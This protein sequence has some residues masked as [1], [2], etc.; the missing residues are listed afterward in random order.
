MI[1][2]ILKHQSLS[3]ICNNFVRHIGKKYNN[4]ITVGE[5]IIERFIDKQINIGFGYKQDNYTPFFSI[6]NNFSNFDVVFNHHQESTGYCALSYAKYTNNIGLIVSTSTCGFT[7]ICKALRDAYYNNNPLLFMSFYDK[8]SKS[9]LTESIKLERQY[10]KESYNITKS[11]ECANALEYMIM[12]SELP[13]QGPVHLNICNSILKKKVVLDE[14]HLRNRDDL[15][16][17]DEGSKTQNRLPDME[18]LSLLQ[19]YEKKYEQIEND[20]QHKLNRYKE[21]ESND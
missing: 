13:Q 7:N 10:L 12:L 14:L 19:Y 20:E 15:S 5:Y 6:A 1:G 16:L 3:K 2:D 21:S 8:E 4:K 18:E 11:R 9:K 17:I